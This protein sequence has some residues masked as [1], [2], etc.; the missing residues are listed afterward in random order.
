MCIPWLL[1]DNSELVY[2]LPFPVTQFIAVTAYQ[3]EDVTTLK[4]DHNPFAKAFKDTRDRPPLSSQPQLTLTSAA[5]AHVLAHQHQQQMQHQVEQQQQQQ[6]LYSYPY[7]Y[8]PPVQRVKE[9]SYTPNYELQ[10][11]GYDYGYHQL[12]THAALTQQ[13]MH[14][15]HHQQQQQQQH[16]PSSGSSVSPPSESPPS[17]GHLS[18]S[19]MTR[20][21]GGGYSNNSE[22]AGLNFGDAAFAAAFSNNYSQNFPAA[23]TAVTTNEMYTSNTTLDINDPPITPPER[24]FRV[25]NYMEKSRSILT[26]GTEYVP[27]PPSESMLSVKDEPLVNHVYEDSNNEDWLPISPTSN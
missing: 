22:F 25:E 3:N 11:G 8:H 17:S 21:G 2:T 15:H 10:G 13:Q 19:S 16:S 20:G 4:I 23:S 12:Y 1:P 27:T 18:S 7:Y 26:S 6:Q 14:Y 5:N 24:P 9:E